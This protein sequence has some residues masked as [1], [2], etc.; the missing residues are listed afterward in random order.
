MIDTVNVSGCCARARSS[1]VE[2]NI[3]SR[4]PSSHFCQVVNGSYLCPENFDGFHYDA[5][6]ANLYKDVS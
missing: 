2:I 3:V 5:T 6:K 1:P 4:V